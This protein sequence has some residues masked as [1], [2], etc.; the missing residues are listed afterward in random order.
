M[1]I[2]RLFNKADLTQ[3]S[4]QQAQ[5]LATEKRLPEALA[6]AQEIITQWDNEAG[7]KKGIF[8][9]IWA[10]QSYETLKEQIKKW[11]TN[12][13]SANE[14]SV[15]AKLAEES[16]QVRIENSSSLSV[17]ISRYQRSLALVEN[18]KVRQAVVRC[19]EELAK[20]QSYL[21]L[22]DTA[23]EHIDQLQYQKALTTLE[24]AKTLFD[25][26]TFSIRYKLVQVG[27]SK[28][29]A[30][31]EAFYAA[32][33]LAISGNFKRAYVLFKPVW[34]D[35]PRQ[36][37]ASLCKQLEDIYKGQEAYRVGVE[38]EKR[39]GLSLAIT[40]YQEALRLLP[41]VSEIV[42]R[43]VIV[44]IKAQDWPLVVKYMVLIE[45]EQADYLRGFVYA[46]HKQWQKALKQWENISVPGIEKQRQQVQF[47]KDY[48]HFAQKKAIQEAVQAGDLK[49]A[50]T[51]SIEFLKND[52]DRQL[53]DNLNYHITPLLS[54]T[55]WLNSNWSELIQQYRQD[56]LNKLAPQDLH[57]WA[58]A[59]YYQALEDP[60]RMTD[61]INPWLLTVANIE[62][63]TALDN[64]PWLSGQAL[65]KQPIAKQLL[66]ILDLAIE[67]CKDTLPIDSYFLLR[68]RFRHD[69]TALNLLQNKPPN[70]VTFKGYFLTPTIYNKLKDRLPKHT[71]PTEIWATLYTAWGQS[72]AACLSGDPVRTKQIKI[73]T[74]PQND[75]EKFAYAYVGYQVGCHYLTQQQ[76]REAMPSLQP[77]KSYL[78]SNSEWRQTI[79]SLCQKQ[80][81]EIDIRSDHLSFGEFWYKLLDSQESKSYYV[82]YKSRQVAE[83]LSEEKITNSQAIQELQSLKSIDP[84]NAIANDLLQTIA[85]IE[86]KERVYNLMK[87]KDFEGAVNFA[88]RASNEEV[89]ENLANFFLEVW[90]ENEHTMSAEE[91]AD[92]A[93]WVRRLC[94]HWF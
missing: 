75:L 80:R 30:Y 52:Q 94:P 82:E 20:R 58:I 64:I 33:Q 13:A 54:R 22:L 4:L 85:R 6:I 34:Q 43:L 35:F 45:G 15:Q 26:P 93:R 53:E 68:D 89:R 59:S 28:E 12:I 66:E 78:A 44:G 10:G 49:K 24:E 27:L 86:E 61:M 19:E 51:M 17:A 32:T 37:G 62:R 9:E 90:Q 7:W 55:A 81:Q 39:G 25:T 72:V 42:T 8:L 63:D 74:K 60:S 48:E 84:H 56:W 23:Q 36:D 21:S 47:S 87:Q 88:C 40:Y 77:I 1:G 18:H 91:K 83:K 79:D 57:N 38:A 76:W 31:L 69:Y 67:S 16:S 5:N 2:F 65:E 92:I 71:L 73:N 70:S 3:N 50:Q 11:Q 29:K 41:Q 46:Q 14:L